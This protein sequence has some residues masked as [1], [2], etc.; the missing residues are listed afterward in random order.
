MALR[1]PHN[2]WAGARPVNHD[3][4]KTTRQAKTANIAQWAKGYA[5]LEAK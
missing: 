3:A 4:S 2:S 5:E 1:K